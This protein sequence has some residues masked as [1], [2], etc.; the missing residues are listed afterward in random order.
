M[1][2]T[3]K[4]PLRSELA[5]EDTWATEDMYVS[6]EAWEAELATIEADKEKLISFA[7]RLGGSGETLCA[8]LTE[9]EKV[10]AKVELLAN[11]CMR[12][13][14]EDTRNAFYQAMSG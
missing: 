9:M 1:E 3:K 13:A 2:E 5:V 6:D 14:D 7:G 4:I 10:D 11:Y 12:K 8:Y